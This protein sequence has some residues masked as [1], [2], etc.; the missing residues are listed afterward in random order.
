MGTAT[1]SWTHVALPVS[2]L[3]TSIAFYE[4]WANMSVLERV[5]EPGA[6]AVRL[7]DGSRPF[8]LVLIEGAGGAGH[9]LDGFGHLGIEF[10]R[11]D[12]VARV[13]AQAHEAGCLRHGPT[14]SGHPR[15]YWAVLIDP[16]G[17]QLELSHGQHNLAGAQ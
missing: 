5:E 13:S 15:G 8:V 17:H 14:D 1:R 3:E 11:R 7:S 12:E 9:P 6:K 16:D 4:R 2:D 10:D